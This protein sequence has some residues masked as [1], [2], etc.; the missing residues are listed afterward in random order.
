MVQNFNMYYWD[1]KEV[2]QR[3]DNRMTNAYHLTLHASKDYNIDMRQ[4]AYVIAVQRVVEAMKLR[5]WC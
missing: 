5:G 1:E 4:A 2:H 3:L